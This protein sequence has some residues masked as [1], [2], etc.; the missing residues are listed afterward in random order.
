MQIIIDSAKRN[1]TLYPNSNQ[2]KYNTTKVYSY[3]R[4]VSLKTAQMMSSDYVINSNNRSFIITV[5]STRYTCTLTTGTWSAGSYATQLQTDLNTVGNWSSNPLLTFTV[6]YSASKNKFTIS[7]TSS[8]IINFSLCYKLAPKLGFTKF[9]TTSATSQTSD[10][11][12]QFFN[13]RYY[14]IRIPQLT[15]DSSENLLQCF[16]RI[17]NTVQPFELMDYQ[18]HRDY[19]NIKHDLNNSTLTPSAI[20]ISIY[21][22]NGDLVDNNNS[23]FLLTIRLC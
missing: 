10:G 17:Y 2:F 23:D 11:S 22:D 4:Y 16:A 5:S 19:F 8:F 15:R 6:T 20:D 3:I 13:S 12:V 7:T 18:S 1:T 9:D 14:D 21:D